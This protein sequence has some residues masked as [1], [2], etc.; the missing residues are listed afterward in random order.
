[1]AEL[2]SYRFIEDRKGAVWDAVLYIPTVAILLL[3]GFKLWY[4]N[5]S[6]W[7]YGLFFMASYI[8]FLGSE[9]IFSTR[10]LK[11]PSS[12]VAL[13]IDKQQVTVELRSKGKV[14]LVK[15]VRF[16]S[17]YAGKSFGLTGTDVGGKK[18][19]FVIHRGQFSDEQTFKDAVSYL[20][21]YK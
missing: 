3:I 5:D 6:T 17:D 21:V 18:R 16:Y 10:L 15:E 7:A 14:D 12:P 19:K 8:T 20:K 11:F 1:M 9:R 13:S 4:G 2:A